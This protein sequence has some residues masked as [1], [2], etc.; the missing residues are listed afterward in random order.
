MSLAQFVFQRPSSHCGNA[1]R[2]I[3][4]GENPSCLEENVV[5]LLRPE[6]CDGDNQN[7]FCGDTQFGPHFGLYLF[8]SR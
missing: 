6:V 7:L 5:A 3:L 1:N 8:L 2:E 4:I